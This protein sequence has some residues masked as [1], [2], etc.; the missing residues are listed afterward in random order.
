[1]DVRSLSV[2]DVDAHLT[3]PVDLWTSRAPSKNADRVA[4][5]E[6][7]TA[8]TPKAAP[9]MT[10]PMREPVGDPGRSGDVGDFRTGGV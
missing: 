7:S 4:T 3:E 10:G 9:R 1:M 5:S 8:P 2:I 6:I